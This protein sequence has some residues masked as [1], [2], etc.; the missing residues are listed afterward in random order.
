[1]NKAFAEIILMKDY[2]I[3]ILCNKKNGVLYTGVTN[4]MKRR[5][6]EH[7]KKLVPGFTQKYNCDRL[8]YFK[9]TP[10]VSTAIQREKQ[11]KG[12]LRSRKIGLI[13]SKNP[14]WLDLSADWFE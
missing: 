3:Y 1:M 14:Q 5:L 6:Y 9:S 13:E 7:K 10:E 12:W 2:Y 4:D 11:L 8:V